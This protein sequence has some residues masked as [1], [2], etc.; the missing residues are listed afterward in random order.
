VAQHTEPTS[1]IIS[2]Q[3]SGPVRYYAGRDT[4][5]FELLD[6]RWLDRA[7]EWLEQQGRKPYFLLEE[8]DIAE[9]RRRFGPHNTLAREMSPMV[10]Y[11]AP[12]IHGWAYLYDP[13]RPDAITRVIPPIVDPR[14][15][16]PLPATRSR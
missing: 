6:E 13:R 12:K 5:R 15:H 11:K 7:V 16:C 8:A 2:L 14:P 9:F 10:A 3:N 4:I 1:V